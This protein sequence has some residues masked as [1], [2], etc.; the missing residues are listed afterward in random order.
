MMRGDACVH[1]MPRHS[2]HQRYCVA[3]LAGHPRCSRHHRC[4]LATKCAEGQDYSLND[5]V[6][7]RA[8]RHLTEGMPVTLIDVRTGTGDW[9]RPDLA[10][11]PA[12]KANIPAKLS[13]RFQ[14]FY[15]GV[16]GW[17]LAP[18][19]WRVKHASIGVDG[20]AGYT[21]VAPTGRGSGWLDYDITPACLSCVLGEADGLLPGA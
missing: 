10:D 12:Y 8:N 9:V 4:T 6:V 21:F 14:L 17:M 11:V 15:G 7:D 19:G 1:S 20:N 16:A 2:K 3:V 18:E 13:G 5:V